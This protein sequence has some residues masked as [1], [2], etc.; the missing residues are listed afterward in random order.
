[1][2][3]IKLIPSADQ[4]NYYMCRDTEDD[5]FVGVTKIVPNDDKICIGSCRL[6]NIGN[7]FINSHH[8]LN[9]LHRKC[10]MIDPSLPILMMSYVNQKFLIDSAIR[11]GFSVIEHGT[12]YIA[13]SRRSNKLDSL[14][15]VTHPVT[16][17]MIIE[18]LLSNKIP[19]TYVS[20]K[21][22]SLPDQIVICHNNN[23]YC[24][25]D[26][27]TMS[28]YRF[29]SPQQQILLEHY[30]QANQANQHN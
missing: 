17:D 23:V 8:L 13:M 21:E 19:N 14:A 29:E 24:H 18:Y 3:D 10:N 6:T 4:Q 12:R 22:S 25:F 11:F 30:V 28:A 9:C 20:F 15:N 5:T 26:T 7:S 2:N 27:Q 16:I 1:M